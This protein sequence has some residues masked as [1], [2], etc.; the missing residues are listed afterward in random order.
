MYVGIHGHAV[1]D[2]TKLKISNNYGKPI[3]FYNNVPFIFKC[4][5]DKEHVLRHEKALSEYRTRKLPDGQNVF[6]SFY[7][8]L[9]LLLLRLLLLQ[10]S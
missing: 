2:N 7:V 8:L 9:L 3:S 4:F 5:H 10:T 6:L 1:Y